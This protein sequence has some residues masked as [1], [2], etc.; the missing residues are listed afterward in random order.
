L[1]AADSHARPAEEAGP[2]AVYVSAGSNVDPAANLRKAVRA[3]AARFGPLSISSVYRNKAVGFEG[4]DFLNAVIGFETRD[5][6]AQVVATLELLHEE[7][8]RVRAAN[9]FG[10][11]TLDLDLLLYGQE[12][13][14]DPARRIRVPHADLA[15]YSFVLG[16]LAEIAPGVRHPGT[17]QTMAELWRDFDK[18]RHPLQKLDLSLR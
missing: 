12:V 1:S 14:D 9:P 7:A 4:D 17:G 3:L 6:P 2:V 11:R 13:I 18:G 10:P 16:P 15:R 5:S 8:G